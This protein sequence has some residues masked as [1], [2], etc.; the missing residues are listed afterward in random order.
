MFRCMNCW[1][2]GGHALRHL[3][4]AMSLWMPLRGLGER[5]VMGR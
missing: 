5:E 4:A 1:E 3:A 2:L